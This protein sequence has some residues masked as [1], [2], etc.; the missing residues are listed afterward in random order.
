MKILTLISLIV[1]IVQYLRPIDSDTKIIL[2]KPTNSCYFPDRCELID[3][4]EWHYQSY[5]V[6]KSLYSKFDETRFNNKSKYTCERYFRK[7]DL[8]TLIVYP[9]SKNSILDNSFESYKIFDHTRGLSEYFS[10]KLI[11]FDLKG[12]HVNLALDLKLTSWNRLEIEFRNVDFDIYND[13][14]FQSCDEYEKDWTPTARKFLFKNFAP[15]YILDFY[16]SR[17]KT[18]ICPLLFRDTTF[19]QLQI[20]DLIKSYYKTN[21][22]QFLNYS[23]LYKPVN[24][25]NSYFI[26]SNFYGLDI[27][28][29]I[30]NDKL[31]VLT[32]DFVFDGAINSIQSDIF[33]PF[34]SMKRLKFNP[35]YLSSLVKRRG[36]EWIKSINHGLR[37]N[38][39]DNR[40]INQSIHLIKDIQ[41]EIS[42][43]NSFYYD[44]NSHF[45]YDQDFCL[46][47]DF[48]FEQLVVIDLYLKF[49]QFKRDL[50]CTTLWLLQF[51]PVYFKFIPPYK[52]YNYKDTLNMLENSES[53]IKKCDFDR[54][55]KLCDKSK[56]RTSNKNLNKM[57]LVIFSKTFYI[58]ITPLVCLFGIITNSQVILVVVRERK[59]L[60]EAQYIYMAVNSAANIAILSIQLISLINECHQPFGVYCSAI[61]K[62]L[63][64]Q[65]FKII[66]V[67]TISSFFRLI[68]NLAYLAFSL[69]RFFLI[70]G[71]N[72]FLGFFANMRIKTYIGISVFISAVLSLIKAFRYRIN[73]FDSGESYPYMFYRNSNDNS[74][75]GYLK[76]RSLYSFIFSTDAVYDLINYVLFTLVNL[77]FDL[78]LLVKIKATLREK[79]EKNKLLL[80]NSSEEVKEKKRKENKETMNRVIL[81]VVLNT[82]VNFVCKIPLSLISINDLR[83]LI[84][85]NLK[86]LTISAAW[87][88]ENFS[89]SVSLLCHMNDMCLLVLE[90]AH[91][92]YFV[93]LSVSF[94]F[95][96]AFDLKFR[97]AYRQ[98]LSSKQKSDK[99]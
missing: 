60:K 87:K 31:F 24:F 8:L 68:S 34:K 64:A 62:R 26:L 70:D 55:I 9:E 4:K 44:P 97:L 59:S 36:I 89:Y 16:N 23:S 56:Y 92:F 98:L 71:Q 51:Y 37:V 35:V 77:V 18:P 13:T 63:F 79:E 69:N 30:L 84:S 85:S 73:S 43:A 28:S 99:K 33:R 21:V 20:N 66:F 88:K 38:L 61:Y 95:F 1:I 42:A 14:L 93:S 50:S 82:L 47:I 81:M 12:F 58:I 49:G 96:Y 5:L 83:L 2:K 40:S 45:F 57:D 74:M 80:A 27:D 15:L 11:L 25:T 19:Y 52:Q 86:D 6:C 91:F 48:P 90:Y 41:F 17:F 94:F 67:E 46:M 29:K 75:N 78:A 72:K 7:S 39:S 53:V 10:Y 54:R 76:L 65:Y 22:V 3:F 32:S